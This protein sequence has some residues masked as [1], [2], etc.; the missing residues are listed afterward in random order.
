[1]ETAIVTALTGLFCT[2]ISSI[3]TFFMT[4]RKYNSEVESQQIKNLNE[5]F[6]LY[7][8]TMEDTLGSQNKKIDML[9]LENNKMNQ[10]VSSLQQQMLNILGSICLDSQCKLRKMNFQSDLRFTDNGVTIGQ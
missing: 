4:K 7:K 9:Q 10:Q 1:M 5:A 2:V 8:K 6:G 3:V